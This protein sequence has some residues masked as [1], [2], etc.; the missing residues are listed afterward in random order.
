MYMVHML[1]NAI[2]RHIGSVMDD[3]ILRATVVCVP[4]LH[5]RTYSLSKI[6]NAFINT[7]YSSY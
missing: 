5:S 2:L 4:K 6:L 3:F 1:I 7:H